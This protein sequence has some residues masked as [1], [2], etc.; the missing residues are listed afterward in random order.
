MESL[1][2]TNKTSETGEEGFDGQK[3]IGGCFDL[4][5]LLAFSIS[6]AARNRL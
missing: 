4:N 2:L 3:T 5:L 1:G 6:V